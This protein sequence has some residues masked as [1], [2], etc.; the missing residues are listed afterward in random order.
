MLVKYYVFIFY[1]FFNLVDD[2][3]VRNI[4]NFIGFVFIIGKFMY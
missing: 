3:L 2:K 4:C 1:I